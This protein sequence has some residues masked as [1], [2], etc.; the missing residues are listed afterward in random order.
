MFQQ[1]GRSDRSPA[2]CDNIKYYHVDLLFC[3]TFSPIPGVIEGFLFSL[4]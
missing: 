1:D 2:Q 4:L 3:V